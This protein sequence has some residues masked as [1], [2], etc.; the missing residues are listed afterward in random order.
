MSIHCG[1]GDHIT[2]SSAVFV[3]QP[4]RSAC[5]NRAVVHHHR[6]FDVSVGA[7]KQVQR[8]VARQFA[9]RLKHAASA[10]A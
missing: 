9:V 6:D 8:V 10:V 2:Q 3:Q 7:I 5:I 1:A 4:L